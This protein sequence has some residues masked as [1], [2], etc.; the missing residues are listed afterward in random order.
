MEHKLITGGIQYLPFARSRI[1][2]LRA[3]GLRYASQRFVFPDASVRVQIIAEQEYIEISGGECAFA[4]DSGVVSL[5]SIAS[6]DPNRYL[7]GV[8]YET[9]KVAAYNAAF[10]LTPPETYWRYNPATTG[11][12][13]GSITKAKAFRGRVPID[14]QTAKSFEPGTILDSSDPPAKISDPADDN[15]YVKKVLAVLCPPSVFTGRCRLWVQSMYGRHMHKVDSDGLPG[16]AVTLP[17]LNLDLGAPALYVKGRAA[18]GTVDVLVDTNTGV[19]LDPTTGRH[20]MLKPSA[21][22]VYIYPL[23]SS[24]CGEQ[25]RRFLVSGTDADLLNQADRDRLEAFVL[26]ECRP[27]TTQVIQVDMGASVQNY[28]MGYGWHWNWTG[29]TADIVVN[30]TFNQD[31]TNSAMRSS[32]HRIQMTPPTDETPWQCTYTLVEGPKDWTLYRAYWTIAEPSWQDG[33]LVKT[34]PKNSTVSACDAPFYAFYV[35]DTLK[36]CRVSV[37]L[38]TGA[39]A[40]VEYYNCS[41]TNC[42]TVGA[43]EGWRRATNA[44]ANHYA[45]VFTCAGVSTPLVPVGATT[46]INSF[47]EVMNKSFGA[48]DGGSTPFPSFGSW[49][50]TVSDDYGTSYSSV[51]QTANMLKQTRYKIQTFDTRVSSGSITRTGSATVVIPFYD[52][53]AVYLQSSTETITTYDSSTVYHLSNGILTGGALGAFL[54]GDLTDGTPSEFNSAAG[55]GAFAA[56]FHDLASTTFE[57]APGNTTTTSTDQKMVGHAGPL[58]ATFTHLSEFHDNTAETVGATFATISSTDNDYPIVIAPGYVSPVGVTSPPSVPALVG[59]V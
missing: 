14:A 9:P 3:A 19:Y 56:D 39:A 42:Y 13:S 44:E 10:V 32:H 28:S 58:T 6:A 40:A 15:L 26:A 46:V 7:P 37:T 38:Q 27:D 50:H 5:L 4:M 36:T 2:A 21:G 35:G 51:T 30:D 48:W 59:W 29:L 54:V 55:Y 49:T 45:A 12:M 1:K 43:N 33:V 18:V 57:T 8:L 34:T 23:K 20:W 17:T 31:S 47:T 52:A 53:E 41:G 22:Y 24:A 25:V 16:D 11:Q